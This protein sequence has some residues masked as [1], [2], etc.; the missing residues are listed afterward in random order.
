MLNEYLNKVCE[1]CI[2]MLNGGDNKEVKK[3][4]LNNYAT[5]QVKAVKVVQN[6]GTI[7]NTIGSNAGNVV[8]DIRTVV[9]N[10]E[11]MKEVETG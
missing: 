1:E 10:E 6:N 7:I 5:R 4:T 9:G 2:E 3:F 11:L 8:D